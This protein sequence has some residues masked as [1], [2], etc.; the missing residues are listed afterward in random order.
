MGVDAP[1]VCSLQGCVVKENISNLKF[2]NIPTTA[3]TAFTA[4]VPII[5]TVLLSMI[6]IMIMIIIIIN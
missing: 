3:T 5:F 4:I 6:I 1:S 2:C